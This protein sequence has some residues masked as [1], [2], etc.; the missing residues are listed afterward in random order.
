MKADLNQMEF[1]HP[2][3]REMTDDLE[4]HFG[5]EFTITSLYRID[6]AGVHG[7]LPLRGIDLSCRQGSLGKL[8]E[9]YI[10]TNWN[11]DPTRN[12]MRCC[13]W[14]STPGGVKH[15]HLQVHPNTIRT[16]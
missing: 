14:H 3:L 5:V 4:K 9:L 10:N 11:Y 1:I 16:V 12:G 15:L 7:Q 13:M 6:D 2:L 8:I